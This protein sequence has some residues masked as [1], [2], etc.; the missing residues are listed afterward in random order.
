MLSVPLYLVWNLQMSFRRKTGIT[1]IFCTGG[2][3]VHL[4]VCQTSEQKR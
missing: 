3:F 2:L 4:I 1:F